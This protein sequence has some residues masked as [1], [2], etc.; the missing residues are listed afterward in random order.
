MLTSLHGMLERLQEFIHLWADFVLQ[1]VAPG[2]C[3]WNRHT[4]PG[5]F[6]LPISQKE[7]RVTN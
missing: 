2:V 7:D 3:I 4:S 6:L 1:L 5:T